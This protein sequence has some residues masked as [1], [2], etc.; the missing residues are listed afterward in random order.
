[1]KT[2]FEQRLLAALTEIDGRRPVVTAAAPAPR[3]SRRRWTR[4]PV[5]VAGALAA[6]ALAGGATAAAKAVF[7][8]KEILGTIDSLRPGDSTGIKGW[9]CEPGSRVT[10]RLDG[11]AI[12]SATAEVRSTEPVVGWFRVTVTI[13]ADTPPGDHV[14]TSTCPDAEGGGDKVLTKPITVT[15]R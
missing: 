13:P 14:L 10:I 1:M 11:T 15:A 4:P 5:V 7:E 6:V 2:G 8:P 12:G 9:G 3:R